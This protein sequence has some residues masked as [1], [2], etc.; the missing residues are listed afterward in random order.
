MKPPSDRP[1]APQLET[2]HIPKSCDVLASHLRQKILDGSFPDGTMLPGERDLVE[3]T[4]L[5]RGSVREALRI[6]EAE[7]LVTTRPGRY[8]GSRATRPTGTTVS[9]QIA[10]FA[11]GSRLP[12]A[13]IIEAREA[14]EPPIAELAARHRTD[15][16]LATLRQIDERLQDAFS[17]VPTYLAENVNWHC[18]LAAASRNPLL[19]AFMR[20][21]ANLIHEAS[22]IKDFANDEVRSLVLK[23]HD[24]ILDAVE[25]QDADA[26]R[27]RMARHVQAYS[28]HLRTL[29]DRPE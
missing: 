25:K 2:L 29:L 10:L 28:V 27:R 4:G 17:D 21:I 20:S 5:S 14:I 16:D 1:L 8:G 11:R 12:L 3:Q 26:A 9:R 7:G 18:A 15:A 19:E 6:L 13:S 22:A 24:R 23:A